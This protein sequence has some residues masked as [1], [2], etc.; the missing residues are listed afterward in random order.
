MGTIMSTVLTRGVRRDAQE[1]SPVRAEQKAEI[2]G[3]SSQM[4]V[5]ACIWTA[6]IAYFALQAVLN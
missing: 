4:I 1:V 6:V 5:F 3:A 2:E